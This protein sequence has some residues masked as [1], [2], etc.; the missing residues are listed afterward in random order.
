[1]IRTFSDKRYIYSVDMMISY[2]RLN[3]PTST[4]IDVDDL[5][6]NLKIDN[7]GNPFKKKYYSPLT[8]I[9][10]PKRYKKQYY[11]IK[12]AELS[13]PIIISPKMS[14]IDGV[15]RLSKSYLLKNKTIK[16][17]IFN[18]SLLKKFIIAK[19]NEWDKVNKMQMY[20]FIE[21]FAK[22]F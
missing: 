7:W 19:A 21:K 3:E 17:Y 5:L 12:N 2:I 18:D 9:R 11:K 1:M 13:F 16:A 15:H 14:I 8:V 6:H 20:Q 10:N 22:K 4:K